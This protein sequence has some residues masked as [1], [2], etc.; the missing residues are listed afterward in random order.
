MLR[1]VSNSKRILSL[2]P[3]FGQS[4]SVTC[5]ING[6]EVKIK[7]RFYN[8]AQFHWVF[9]N[10]VKWVLWAKNSFDD[11]SLQY[12]L[13]AHTMYCCVCRH[14]S[15]RMVFGFAVVVGFFGQ[16]Q[17]V[18]VQIKCNFSSLFSKRCDF[19]VALCSLRF[20]DKDGRHFQ[21]NVLNYVV[22]FMTI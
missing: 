16:Q 22:N 18:R 17:S 5:D 12:S 13:H 14:K 4:V 6:C 9:P 21:S 1:T 20:D 10:A 8:A 15:Y 2:L 11:K 19:F 3:C 7:K